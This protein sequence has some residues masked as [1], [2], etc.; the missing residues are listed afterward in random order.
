MH[1]EIIVNQ[2]SDYYDIL[3]KGKYKLFYTQSL[4]IPFIQQIVVITYY[5]LCAIHHAGSWEIF[6]LYSKNKGEQKQ[7]ILVQNKIAT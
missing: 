5:L 7:I 1:F 6:F 2:V 3:I 4:K